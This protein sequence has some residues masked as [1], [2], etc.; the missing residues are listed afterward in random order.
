MTGAEIAALAEAGLQLIVRIAELVRAASKGDVTAAEA[1]KSL[2][3]HSAG[4]KAVTD[5]AHA[6]LD[7]KFDT[8]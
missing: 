5:E 6:Y 2:T 7:K 8:P 1:L 4:M 3:E